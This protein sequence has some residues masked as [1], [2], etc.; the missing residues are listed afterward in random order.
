MNSKQVTYEALF[1]E[2][3]RIRRVEEKIIE[4]YPTDKIQS[5]VH[6]S[7]GQ[8]HHVPALTK[9]LR[10]EDKTFTTYRGHALYISIGGCLKKLFAELY[11]KQAGIC[12]GKA[13]SMHLC[14]P[15]KNMMGSSAIVGAVISHALGAAYAEATKKTDN[16]SVCIT[17]EGATEEGTF[18]ECLNFASLKELPFLMIVENNGLA[19]H[20]P[21]SIRQSYSLE[22]LATAYNIEYHKQD[23]F[24]ISTFYNFSKSLVASMREKRRPVIVEIMTYRYREHVGI[25]MD[26]DMG[27]RGEK[28]YNSWA[29]RDP[30]ILEKDLIARFSNQIDFEIKAAVEFAENSAFPPYDELLKDVY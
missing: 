3:L 12:K 1:Y 26:Y 4:I 23:G 7:I 24:D 19:I 8:E 9:N 20:S 6:L 11:G 28:E 2:A 25:R 29:S 17:G 22:K 27:Y 14:D 13:G 21:L 5:P 16:I 30:L 15:G 18:H 10:A